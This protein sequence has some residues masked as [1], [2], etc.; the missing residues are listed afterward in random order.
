MKVYLI[1]LLFA[2]PV[3]IL[4]Q[5][6]NA[7]HYR[8]YFVISDS[9]DIIGKYKGKKYETKRYTGSYELRKN[10]RLIGKDRF[11]AIKVNDKFYLDVY[12]DDTFHELLIYNFE[13]KTYIYKLEEKPIDSFTNLKDLINQ[14]LLFYAEKCNICEYDE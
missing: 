7:G 13:T 3:K 8:V 12:D 10:Y 14:G 5:L 1:L 2:L 9:A 6:N 11:I 4:S